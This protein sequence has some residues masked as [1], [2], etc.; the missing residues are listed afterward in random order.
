MKKILFRKLMS[1]YLIFLSLALLST[2]I[3]IWV[4]QA[5]NYLDIMIEDGRDY[6]V[7]VNFSLL[8]FPKILSKLFPFILFFT[9]FYVTSKYEQNNE[10]MI[11]WNF[12]V[13][14]IHI[15][16]FVFKISI[17][18]MLFQIF[19]NSFV[20]PN[21]QDMARS[22]LR[23]STVNFFGN[24]V[25]PQK[26]NDTIKGL[27]I[28]ADN[29]DKNGNLDNLYLKKEINDQE[30]QVT[31]AKK[32]EFKEIGNT[33]VLVLYQ[34]ATITSKDNKI[35]NIS[36]SKS[37][38]P[39]ANLESN[40]TTYKKTQEI[41]STKLIRCV[42]NYY[43]FNKDDLK[44]KSGTI[45]NCTTRNMNNIF[46]ELYK[47]FVIPLYIPVLSLIPFLIIIISKENSKYQKLRIFTFLTGFFVI[48]FSEITIRFISNL[49][50]QN[51]IL[52]IIPIIFL[53]LFYFFLFNKFNSN[54]KKVNS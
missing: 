25:K 47:R 30:F 26:F 9:L 15:I 20:V 35:T 18:L 53:I 51:I 48:V 21:S 40:T 52:A 24:F 16:N 34:G 45:E 43:K 33:P 19:L 2:G 10:L 41:S 14:K 4:F 42:K 22:F 49:T 54:F 6:L 32:G 13:H 7:Y 46:K 27:T 29:K 23:T 39:L 50:S 5:V 37:D 38:F 1:D 12:G 31:Y 3:V 44:L 8:N 36:F 17:F 28:Y 11:F